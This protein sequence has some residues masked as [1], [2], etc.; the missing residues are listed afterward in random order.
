MPGTLRESDSLR[1]DCA[2]G[3][4]VYLA[5]PGQSEKAAT[6]RGTFNAPPAV[7]STTTR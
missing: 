3:N 7:R 2:H 5:A 1:C 4:L 6:G